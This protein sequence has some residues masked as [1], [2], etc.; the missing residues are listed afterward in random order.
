MKNALSTASEQQSQS[1]DRLIELLKIPSISTDFSYKP[2]CIKAADLL[3]GDLSSIGFNAKRIDCE[4]MPFVLASKIEDPSK[5][6]LLLYGHYDVQ[7]VDPIEEWDSD[8]FDPQLINKNGED[9]IQARGAA[10][11]KGQL[12]TFIE[13]CRYILEAD[14]KLPVN[15]KILLEGEEESGSP[16]LEA[17]LED[18]K[19]QL[20][21]DIVFVCD[22]NMWNANTPAIITQLRGLVSMEITVKAANRDLHSGYYGGAARNPIHVL[23][24]I[25]SSLHDENGTVTVKGFY[26]DVI[27]PSDEQLKQWRD[28]NLTEDDFLGPIGLKHAAGEEKYSLIEQIWSRPTCEI[29]GISGG[30]SGEGFKTVIPSLAKVKLSCRLVPGQNP[31]K[32]AKAIK[33]HISAMIAEDC[34]V[35][36]TD[37]GNGP[38][39]AIDTNSPFMAGA[40][41]G[42][43]QEWG[44]PPVLAGCGGSIPIIG[45]FKTHLG[46]DSLLIG[47]GLDD[48]SIHSP[49][50]KYNLSSYLRGIRS[51]IQIF[52][53]I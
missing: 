7:P 27:F 14:G 15:L 41:T 49:N 50:E 39:I 9:I 36:F 29:N 25:I 20:K 4:G 6:T 28:L 3:V 48:D 37:F 38:G 16:S 34:D 46:L 45:D 33:E 32:I 47:F 5:P 24:D 12:M 30:Y 11:D 19:E 18:Y 52:Y 23:A 53:A 2:D 26:D 22:T 44:V 42:L 43:E 35:E 31:E 10:D 13:A 40:V 8:P 17:F 1:I 51:W 21:S